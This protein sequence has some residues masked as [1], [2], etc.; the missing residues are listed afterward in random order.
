MINP[1][2][3]RRNHA[4]AKARAKRGQ[5]NTTSAVKSRGTRDER[6]GAS[7]IGGPL[8]RLVIYSIYRLFYIK[9]LSRMSHSS[10]PPQAP[11]L[12]NRF[13]YTQTIHLPQKRPFHKESLS[14]ALA[15]LGPPS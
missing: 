7:P 14:L 11:S 2:A 4:Q 15:P 6:A 5:S 10:G 1:N 9:S 8:I 3:V 13:N 12:V